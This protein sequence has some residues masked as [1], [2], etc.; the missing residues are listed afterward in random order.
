MKVKYIDDYLCNDLTIGK[1]YDVVE[2]YIYCYIIRTDNGNID[3][4][5]KYWFKPLFEIIKKKK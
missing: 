1:I 5:P 3:S 4:Y 2:E